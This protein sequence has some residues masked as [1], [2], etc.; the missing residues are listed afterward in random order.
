MVVKGIDISSH[1]DKIDIEKLKADNIEFV[2]IRAGFTDYN[3]N[4]TKNTDKS[5][6]DNY[7]LFR[8]N[9]FKIGTYYTFLA[10]NKEEVKEEVDYF[11]NIIKDKVFEYPIT[12][13][14]ED[15]HSTIIYYPESQKTIDKEFLMYIV[16]YIYEK[17]NN[18]GYTILIRTYEDWYH[19]TFDEN[20]KYNFW[21][22][23]VKNDK[24][25]YLF[26]S[27]EDDIIYSNNDKTN[28]ISRDNINITLE[29]NC[30]FSVVGNYIKAGYKMLKSKI[31]KK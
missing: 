25:K 22:D 27:K 4:K 10:T 20:T 30:F 15:D 31:R 16:N 23:N 11:L 17:L 8:R 14:I 26:Y 29:E 12:I 19:N 1:S 7:E 24:N 9:N 2:M 13:Q 28:D 3:N 21:I 5:F 18:M 6:Y